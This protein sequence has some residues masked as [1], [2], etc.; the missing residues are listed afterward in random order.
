MIATYS[1]NSELHWVLLYRFPLYCTVRIHR[2]MS[3]VNTVKGGHHY[4]QVSRNPS[5]EKLRIVKCSC[6]AHNII[7]KNLENNTQYLMAKNLEGI[8]DKNH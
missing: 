1:G 5:L 8:V 6:V 3:D 2:Q 7:A 4:D